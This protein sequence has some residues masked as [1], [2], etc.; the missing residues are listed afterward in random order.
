[1][2]L[3]QLVQRLIA[4]SLGI[5]MRLWTLAREGPTYFLIELPQKLLADW[6]N[7]RQE[8]L[9]MCRKVSPVECPLLLPPHHEFGCA[10]SQ[11]SGC[12]SVLQSVGH[13]GH[14]IDLD[15]YLFYGCHCCLC[16]AVFDCD[17]YKSTHL[18]PV[19]RSPVSTANAVP[20]TF[21]CSY[22]HRLPVS[23]CFRNAPTLQTTV[24]IF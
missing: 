1:M 10:A 3:L 4:W 13:P 22:H 17:S 14:C 6:R 15:F 21:P 5:V 2:D 8:A 20:S 7:F 24:A 12:N 16:A 23:L 9:A 11:Y 18:P 19:L